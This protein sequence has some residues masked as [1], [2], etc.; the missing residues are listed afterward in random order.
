MSDTIRFRYSFKGIEE[1]QAVEQQLRE[2]IQKDTGAE[3]WPETRTLPPFGM[4]PPVTKECLEKL[5]K[6][7]GVVINQEDE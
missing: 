5:K 2:L 6:L 1:W 7:D 3:Y 4:P